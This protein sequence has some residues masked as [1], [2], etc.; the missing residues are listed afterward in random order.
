MA[1]RMELLSRWKRF[2]CMKWQVRRVHQGDEVDAPRRVRS[3]YL[4]TEKRRAKMSIR[5]IVNR[6]FSCYGRQWFA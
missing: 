4:P 2:R 5:Y 3:V 1:A 6:I